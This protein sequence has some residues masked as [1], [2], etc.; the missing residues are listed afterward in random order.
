MK[1]KASVPPSREGARSTPGSDKPVKKSSS[2]DSWFSSAALREVVESI[3]VAFVLAFLFRT[4]EA[5]AFVIPTGSMAPTLMGRHK[6]VECPKCGYHY[7]VSASAEMDAKTNTRTDLDVLSGTCPIC[8]YTVDLTRGDG[9]DKEATSFKGD[10][11]LVAKFPYQFHTPQRWD[12]A[13]FMNPGEARINY[14]KRLVGLPEETLKISHGNIYVRPDGQDQFTIARKPPDKILATMQVV[15]DSDFQAPELIAAGWPASWSSGPDGAWQTA[16]GKSFR[17]DGTARGEAWLNYRH[18]VPGFGVWFEVLNGRPIPAAPRPE[19]VTDFVPYNTEEL[20]RLRDLRAQR[21]GQEIPR[22]LGQPLAADR[23]GLHWVSDLVL[24]F[25]LKVESSSGQVVADL[26]KG[27]RHFQCEFD[28]ATGRATLKGLPG[29]EP[30]AMTSV[31]GPGQ[32]RIRF[33]NVDDQLV[34]WVR[35][36]GLA[37]RDS[38]IQFDPKDTTY[39]SRKLDLQRPRPDDLMPVHIASRGVAVEV[40]HLRVFRDLYYIAVNLDNRGTS[41]VFLD[42]HEQARRETVLTDWKFPLNTTRSDFFSSPDK[43]NAFDN[44]REVEFTLRKDQFFMLGDNSAASQ[45]GRLWNT[46]SFVDRDLLKGKAVFI[47]WPHSWE[48][49]PGFP[50]VPRGIPFPFFPNFGRMGFVR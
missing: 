26:A 31:R 18:F 9:R 28:L 48:R 15:D 42:E 10:R 36:D 11:I 8:H 2:Q 43:W 23:S 30:T 13:V 32:Y 25:T 7:Q 35:G 12:V 37:S 24:E 50:L 45:D 47:Y 40:G 34:V 33:A 16:D 6:D 21:P 49:T 44:L 41:N 17:T 5:E 46:Q 38:V 20:G 27:G 22:G 14:I 4:F 1:K 29:V 19:L 3:V 39:D